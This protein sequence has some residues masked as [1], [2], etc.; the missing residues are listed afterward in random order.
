M[1]LVGGSLSAWASVSQPRFEKYSSA[2]EPDW[3]KHLLMDHRKASSQTTIVGQI[4]LVQEVDLAR[5]MGQDRR[6]F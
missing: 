3:T 2:V 1:K 4:F 5:C 6:R